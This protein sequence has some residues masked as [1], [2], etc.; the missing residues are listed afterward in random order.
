MSKIRLIT[1]SLLDFNHGDYYMVFNVLHAITNLMSYLS[2]TCG[3][4]GIT[5]IYILQLYDFISVCSI[6]TFFLRWILWK[7]DVD[8]CFSSQKVCELL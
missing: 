4:C 1:V 5:S 2:G 6:D 7:L 8:L 3:I